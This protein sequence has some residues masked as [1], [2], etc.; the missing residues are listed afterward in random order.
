MFAIAAANVNSQE[1]TTV[2]RKFFH[3][4][5]SLI[6]VSGLQFDPQ[7]TTLAVVL[8]A[9]AFACIEVS[10]ASSAAQDGV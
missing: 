4:T 10:G 3:L 7:L 9:C 8:I 5:V 6:A 1:V 2:H